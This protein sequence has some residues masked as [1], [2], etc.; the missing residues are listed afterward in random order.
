MAEGGKCEGAK[1][2]TQH[3]ADQTVVPRAT[4]GQVGGEWDQPGFGGNPKNLTNTTRKIQESPFLTLNL[5]TLSFFIR[6]LDGT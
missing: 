5:N 4:H 6:A 1:K 3:G 2:E